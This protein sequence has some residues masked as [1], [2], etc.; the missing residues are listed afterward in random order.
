MEPETDTGYLDDPCV[1]VH[2]GGVRVD[3]DTCV[4]HG[5]NPELNLCPLCLHEFEEGEQRFA[6]VCGSCASEKFGG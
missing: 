1:C 3:A 4:M 5:E 6:G 2:R